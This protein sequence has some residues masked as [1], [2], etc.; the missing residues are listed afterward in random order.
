MRVQY[1]MQLVNL[2]IDGERSEEAH[3]VLAELDVL[4][5]GESQSHLKLQTHVAEAYLAA[6]D[7]PAFLQ[8][9]TTL[10]EAELRRDEAPV[11]VRARLVDFR[12]KA[13][14]V[15]MC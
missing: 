8:S 12:F 3:A 11:P 10:L 9:M 6:G 13:S 2:L 1:M 5:V 7:I 4:T 14:V 15:W